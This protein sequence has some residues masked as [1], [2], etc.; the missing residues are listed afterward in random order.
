MARSRLSYP[1]R[2]SPRLAGYNYTQN[3]AYFVTIKVQKQLRLFGDV[4]EERVRLSPAG[5]M[6]EQVWAEV[7][8]TY[9]GVDV[10]SFIVMPDHVHAILVLDNLA[11]GAVSQTRPLALPDI[12]HR[13]KSFT[14]AEYR[15]GVNQRHWPRFAGTLWQRSY[16]DHIIRN[17]A[18]LNRI[19]EYIAQ[20]PL[21]WTLHHPHS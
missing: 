17:D 8:T 20:N 16:H 13:F 9:A 14:T 18:D 7:P 3:G 21:R 12:V 11:A 15:H 6:V 1:Q 10:D 19:R 4:E 2:R 5:E